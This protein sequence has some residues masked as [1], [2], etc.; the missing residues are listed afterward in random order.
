MNNKKIKLFSIFGIL[1]PL[2]ILLFMII[3]GFL[4]QD[5]NH[6]RDFI[7]ELGAVGAPYAYYMN[8]FGFTFLGVSLIFFGSAL[9]N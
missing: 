6:L 2:V 5:Y 3:L 4:H 1:G 7:S 8:Y 9:Y